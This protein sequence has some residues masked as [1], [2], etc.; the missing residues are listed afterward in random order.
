MLLASNQF[1]ISQPRAVNFV[2][3]AA[4][5]CLN[6]QPG[7]NSS[8]SPTC[9][10]SCTA[11]PPPSPAEFLLLQLGS[12]DRSQA[13]SPPASPTGQRRIPVHPTGSGAGPEVT[14]VSF[15]LSISLN[16][17][18]AGCKTKALSSGTACESHGALGATT[19]KIL[20]MGKPASCNTPLRREIASRSVKKWH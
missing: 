16:F 9:L 1:C 4:H 7:F 17:Q 15:S 2:L 3:P 19:S 18:S 14:W 11:K 8:P 6:L 20:P 10:S 5:I 13:A 12:Q